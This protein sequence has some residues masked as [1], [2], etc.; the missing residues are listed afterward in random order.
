[1]SVRLPPEGSGDTAKGHLSVLGEVG[2]KVVCV[3][4]MTNLVKAT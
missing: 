3:P 2:R 1:M 4:N